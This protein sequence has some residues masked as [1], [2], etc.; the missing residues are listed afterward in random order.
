MIPPP[1]PTRKRTASTNTLILSMKFPLMTGIGIDR[2]IPYGQRDCRS[3]KERS[4]FRLPTLQISL[5]VPGSIPN[6]TF[7]KTLGNFARSLLLKA[8]V[9]PRR[10]SALLRK[11]MA[12][13]RTAG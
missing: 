13:P 8:K 2:P 7:T 5:G 9:T 3:P 1:H 6:G 11:D 10:H 4:N 12:E